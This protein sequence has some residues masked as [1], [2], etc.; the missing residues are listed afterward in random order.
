MTG[1]WFAI[2]LALA[3]SPSAIAAPYQVGLD[4]RRCRTVAGPTIA[5]MGPDWS[6]L[7]AHVQ[8]CPVAGPDGRLALTVDIVRLDHPNATRTL[9]ANPDLRI[10]FPIVRDAAGKTVGL[11]PEGF[12]VEPPGKLRVTFVDWRDGIPR[13]IDLHEAGVSALAPHPLPPLLWNAETRT[14]H[15]RSP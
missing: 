8:R 13:R 10:P 11:L 14:Y 4:A 6:A 5:G 9:A 15:R 1:R 3:A 2:G 12:P 7:A